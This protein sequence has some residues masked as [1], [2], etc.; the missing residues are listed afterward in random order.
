MRQD[1]EGKQPRLSKEDVKETKEE[2]EPVGIK[3]ERKYDFYGYV[4]RIP[5]KG[6]RKTIGKNMVRAKFTAPHVTH[7]DEADVTKL[8]KVRQEGKIVAE[9]QGI[10][11]TY[12]PFIIKALIAS[13]RKHPFVNS[14]LDEE[15]EEIILKKYYNIGVA[16]DTEDGLLVPVIKGADQKGVLDLAKEIVELSDKAKSRKIDLGDMKGGTFTITNI[17]SLGGIFAVPIINYPEVAILALGRIYDKVVMENDKPIVKKHL[18][19]SVSFDHRVVDGAEIARFATDLI[20]ILE[21][22]G[23]MLVS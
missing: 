5:Y 21:E 10:K 2:A 8:A 16:V 17:G 19:F 15:N 1:L 12:L 23:M 4:D 18:P 22:P 20:K 13:L 14:T 11:L 9:A 3:H 7:M 6:I